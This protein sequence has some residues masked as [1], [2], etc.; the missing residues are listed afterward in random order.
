MNNMDKDTR[1][2]LTAFHENGGKS[3]ES[4]SVM[5]NRRSYEMSKQA[6]LDSIQLPSVNDRQ[7]L[8]RDKESIN[9]RI[10]DPRTTL[11]NQ[12]PSPAII[13]IHGGGW[14]VGSL[15][16]HDSICRFISYHT[17]LPV[18]AIEY[19]LAPEY[20]FP[21]PLEDCI[22]ALNFITLQSDLLIDHKN[23]TIMGDS[24]GGNLATVIAHQFNDQTQY[25]I[26]SEI[27]FYPVTAIHADTVSYDRMSTGFPLSS[28]TM[29]WFIRQYIRN[30]TNLNDPRHSPILND[31]FN[32]NIKSFIITVGL[33]P[34][35]DEGVEY[36][37]KLIKNG[38]FVEFHHL[39]DTIHGILTS[40]KV[41]KL[42]EEYLLKSCQFI[43]NQH[44]K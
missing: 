13:Y 24:A 16:S 3:F 44:S 12:P 23:L 33:D 30:E 10:Y 35:C 7:L 4:Y 40:A 42:G 6:R 37:A 38:S 21:I 20:S 15:E 26:T 31:K 41:I 36:A 11:E 28:Q 22:D 18:I 9:I 32:Q 19:R 34:L 17:Q 1:K 27:L 39:P 2:I 8:T 25:N 29:K 43:K 14:V 5:E